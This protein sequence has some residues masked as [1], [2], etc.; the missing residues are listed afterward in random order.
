MTPLLHLQVTEL[1]AHQIR[2]AADWW[3]DNRPD[4]SSHLRD[5]LES[6]FRLLVVQPFAGH[7]VPDSRAPGVR[8]SLL[9]KTQHHR[10]Y[11]VTADPGA[12]VILAFWGTRRGSLPDL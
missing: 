1:A 4:V 12:V 11:R 9:R 6:A 5:E 2:E 7:V 8:R 10:Y 3:Q